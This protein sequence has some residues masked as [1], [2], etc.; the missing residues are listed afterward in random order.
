MSRPAVK[1]AVAGI[2]VG[3]LVMLITLA[4]VIGFKSEITNKVV[5]FGSHIQVVNFDNNNTYQMKSIILDDEIMRQLNHI[6]GVEIAQPFCTKPG[7]IKTDSAFQGI[8]LKGRISTSTADSTQS[9][10]DRFFSQNL[11]EGRLPQK[12]NEVII[13]TRQAEMLGLKMGDSFLC[14][15]IDQNI[16]ARK[17]LICGLYDTKFAEYDG[18]FIIGDMKEVQR[19]NDWEEKE[20]SGIEILLK[21][22]SQLNI[23]A[24]QVYHIT[25]NRPDEEGNYLYAQ[26]IEELNPTIFSWLELLNMNVVIIIVLMLCVSGM[27]IISG[28][29]ILIL[30]SIN[31]I[32]TLKA[33]G[34]NNALLRKAFFYEASFLI[35]KG[36][37]WG[38]VV[39]IVLLL[40]QYFTH[41]IPLDATTYYVS[42]VP[43]C[44]PWWAW[45]LMNVGT[46]IVSLLVIILP[47][48][49]VSRISPAKVMHFE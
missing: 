23:V 2:A 46:L 14:Y 25:A 17:Y 12:N 30:D 36:M 22:F 32:G 29:I 7:I 15:F 10:A 35:G 6:P 45:L 3:I 18:L 31:F 9:A 44:L 1:V 20:V 41:I 13:S 24:E 27:C 40:I 16:R 38:N 4:V 26:T 33:L 43:I 19:L 49:I 42:Y 37:I 47:T 5:G 39:A 34:A 28:L 21:D 48:I 8:V 11:V